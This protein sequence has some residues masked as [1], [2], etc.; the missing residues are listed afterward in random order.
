MYRYINKY[1]DGCIVKL[2]VWWGLYFKSKNKCKKNNVPAAHCSLIPWLKICTF[3]QRYKVPRRKCTKYVPFN[4]QQFPAAVSKFC[5]NESAAR[6]KGGWTMLRDAGNSCR[7]SLCWSWYFGPGPWMCLA[8]SSF[9]PS[10]SL[11]PSDSRP[12]YGGSRGRKGLAGGKIDNKGFKA[13]ELPTAKPLSRQRGARQTLP[14]QALQPHQPWQKAGRTI[15]LTIWLSRWPH[16]E[17]GLSLQLWL[18]LWLACHW[19]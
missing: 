13:S 12:S 10:L 17:M 11:S 1:T 8:P 14:S 18:V 6:E 5:S 2:F 4:L 9:L 7:E 3:P 19:R 16:T 15:I